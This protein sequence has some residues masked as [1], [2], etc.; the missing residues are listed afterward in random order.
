MEG[1]EHSTAPLRIP[2]QIFAV[3]HEPVGVRVMSYH[4]PYV[5]RQ[6]LNALDPEELDTIRSSP[7]GKLVEIGENPSFEIR[8]LSCYNVF[9]FC[10][11]YRSF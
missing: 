4:K 3:G 7:F 8:C 5:I 6:I 2:D 10:S 1:D 11:F 9:T